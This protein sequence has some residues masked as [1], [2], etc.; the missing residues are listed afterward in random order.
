[1]LF[2]CWFFYYSQT[3]NFRDIAGRPYRNKYLCSPTFTRFC[4]FLSGMA[5][6]MNARFQ[7]FEDEV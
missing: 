1:M 6:K 2:L 5:N 3:R 4:V 7:L